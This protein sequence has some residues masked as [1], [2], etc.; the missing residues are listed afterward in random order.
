[1][2]SR[3]FAVIGLAVLGFLR[4]SPGARAQGLHLAE[5]VPTASAL[6]EEQS[7]EFFVRFNRPIDHAHSFFAIKRNGKVVETLRP[8]LEADP[9]MLYAR[10]PTPKP[11]DYTLHWILRCRGSTDIYQGELPFTVNRSNARPPAS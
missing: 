4:L 3:R 6:I 9:N 2:T 1:M 10:T 11:G 5:P 7:S 8:R